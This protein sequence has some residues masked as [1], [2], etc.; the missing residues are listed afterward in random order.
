M[1][2]NFVEQGSAM[3]VNFVPF[4]EEPRLV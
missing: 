4:T 3:V 1:T 2:Q